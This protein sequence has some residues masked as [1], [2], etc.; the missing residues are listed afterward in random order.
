MGGVYFLPSLEVTTVEKRKKWREKREAG[1]RLN[2]LN[3]TR[4]DPF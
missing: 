4:G 1:K 2:T 3:G